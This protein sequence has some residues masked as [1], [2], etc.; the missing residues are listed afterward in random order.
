MKVAIQIN[1][2]A[3]GGS[4]RFAV[5]LA[6]GLSDQ[7][8]AVTLL[9]G[10]RQPDEYEVRGTVNRVELFHGQKIPV[11]SLILRHYLIGHQIDVCVAIGIVANLTAALANI[12]LKTRMILCERNAP[13]EDHLSWK[14]KLLRKLLYRRGDAFVFQTPDARAFYSE[15]IQRKGVVIPNPVKEGLPRRSGVA[16][17][18]IVAVGRLRPQKNYPLLLKAFSKVYQKHSDY[19]LRIFGKGNGLSEL[20]GLAQ[21]LGINQAVTFEGFRTDVHQ[22]MVDSDIYVMSSDFEGMPNALLEA[23]A[24]GFPVVSTDCPCGGPRMLIKDRE[25]GLLTMVGDVDD[26]ASAINLLI[27]E[28]DLKQT[29]ASHALHLNEEYALREII[30][31]WDKLLNFKTI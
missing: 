16:R 17:K 11:S 12:M 15:S 2:I 13:K 20:M 5:L 3:G 8:Y 7:G 1:G 27:E 6:N 26:L 9:T 21:T 22:A 29:C 28:P 23:M 30:V 25:N 10:P 24:M 4:E 14:S 19:Q 18:E 31:K